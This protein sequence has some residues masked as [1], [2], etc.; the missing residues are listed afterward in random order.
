MVGTKRNPKASVLRGDAGVSAPAV[1]FRRRNREGWRALSAGDAI[2]A[3][4]D[5]EISTV[6]SRMTALAR[7]VQILRC[8]STANPELS[9]REIIARTGLPRATVFRLTRVLRQ[10]GL[11]TFVESRSVFT[12]SLSLLTMA[13]PV[14]TRLT[15]RQVARPL[16]QSLA[17]LIQG[18]VSMVVGEGLQ[19]VVVEVAQ[20]ANSSVFRMEIGARLSLARTVTGRAYL[21]SLPEADQLAYL[22]DV[23]GDDQER[24]DA[25]SAKL[26]ATAS[27]LGDRGYAIDESEFVR[28]LFAVAAPARVT[29][30]G[31]RTVFSC[32][33]PSFVADAARLHDIGLRLIAL[34][35]NVEASIGHTDESAPTLFEA[36]NN[37]RM[38]D[39]RR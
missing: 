11:L 34:V 36:A 7:G 5:S 13:A 19:M 32:S 9:N 31:R 4:P 3:K 33:V 22:D 1:D 18:Q 37:W 15:T 16:M 2:I 20:G 8:F 26:A 24:R 35:H 23:A 6:E 12:L 25:L 29:I 30:D 27:D 14:L 21:L 39:P 28:G 38:P 17:D 10:L